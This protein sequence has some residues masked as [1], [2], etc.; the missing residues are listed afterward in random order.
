MKEKILVTGGAGYIG[1][2]LVPKLLDLGYSVRVLD[3]M[4]YE[5]NSLMPYFIDKN[6]E[7]VNGDIRNFNTVNDCVKGTDYIIH[8][9][10][11]VGAPACYKNQVEA[12]AINYGGSENILRAR[13]H[14]NL[15]YPSSGSCYGKLYDICTE[16]SPTYPL[17]LYS[18]TKLMTEDMIKKE[19]DYVIF[20]P[21][22][23]FGLSPRMRLDLLPN[24]FTYQAV[25]NG[26]I[27]VYE[28]NARRTFIHVRDLADCFVFAVKNFSK[29][30]GD[31][32]NVGSDE[33]N[34]TKKELALE[35]RSQVNYK[36]IFVDSGSDPD[37]RDYQVSYKKIRDK[38][39]RTKINMNQGISELIKGY[40]MV[41]IRNPYSNQR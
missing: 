15:I 40:Q 39:F 1:S 17:T 21:A 5:Q 13:T 35:I 32:Y 7:F 23:A 41:S 12:E 14:H 38:G 29:L 10:A 9:A 28:K 37:K 31:V 11:I 8:L 34:C 6:F 19:D 20:R 3:N 30:N 26:N 18:K 27:V 22:T 36:L 4:M 25:K 2:I 16:K 33:M 24:D